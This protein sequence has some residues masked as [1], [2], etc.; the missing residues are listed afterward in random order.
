M[1]KA[2]LSF[3]VIVLCSACWSIVAGAQEKP[4]SSQLPPATPLLS[5]AI[6]GKSN[7]VFKL[8]EQPVGNE[9]LEIKCQPDGG[10][11]AV[12]RTELKVP[13]ASID[14]NTTLDLDK[15]GS[16]TSSSAKGSVAGQPFDQSV[17]I[18]D[19]IATLT[20]GKTRQLPFKEGSALMGGN[21]FY[22]FHFAI[23]RYD[24]ARGGLQEISIFPAGSIKVER[25]ARDALVPAN[26]PSGAATFDRY[27]VTAGGNVIVVWFDSRG[28]L[29]ALAIPLQNFG[30]LREDYLALE[31]AFKGALAAK[32]KAIEPDYSA[33][34]G[35]AFT[36]EEVTVQAKGFTLAGTL[37][38]PKSGKAP[39]PAVITIT[40]SGQQTRDERLPLPGLE[41]YRPFGQIA[42]ALANRGVAVLRVD[43]RG[44]G[45]S[46]GIQTLST[47][48]MTDFADDVRAQVAY[49]RARREIDP[50]RIALAGHSEGGVIAPMVAGSDSEIAAIVLMAGTAKRGD[51]VLEF[52]V[53]YQLDG[54]TTL[55]PE[56][57]AAKRAEQL[58][59]IRKV[60]EGGD[61]SKL[62]EFMR[63][64]WMRHFLTYDPLPAIARVRQ[65]I[66]ILQGEI[67]RQVTADQ[68]QM[69]EKAAR[70]AG[71]K[72]VSVRVFPGLNHLFLP[73][74]TG[75]PSEYT[76]LSTTTVGEDVIKQLSDWL[77]V[78]LGAK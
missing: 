24:A 35:A 47:V 74:K 44:V 78:R 2:F 13:G 61:T 28:R 73:A 34:A 32:L 54:D 64:P 59:E 43:D 40:G 62:S 77:I 58:A 36:A 15:S 5:P 38:L 26:L 33:P 25:V 46:T 10:Y 49:L 72:D 37:L 4:A 6:C 63:S 76:S 11:S 39:F 42:E 75:A 52:Q 71:N 50:K 55:T 60:V 18:K 51:V 68:A 45:K 21:I 20:S 66:L 14:L 17:S 19:G 8:G 9:A 12:G 31:G 7:L 53:N 3:V 70:T 30:A 1:K 29:A 48:T 16:P 56:A 65:P 57:K 27:E 69:I 41:K 23:A 22:M 67:D